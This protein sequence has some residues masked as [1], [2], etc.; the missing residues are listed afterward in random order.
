V[1]PEEGSYFTK[2]DV[3]MYQIAFGQAAEVG[4]KID[5][6]VTKLDS[7]LNAYIGVLKPKSKRLLDATST[8]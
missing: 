4:D 3:C 1:K 8:E 6:K 2:G 7:Q 5:L